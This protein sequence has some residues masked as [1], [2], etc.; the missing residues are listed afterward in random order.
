MRHGL[1]VLLT[2]NEE[3]RFSAA[4][5]PGPA[6]PTTG[7]S[8]RLV[9]ATRGRLSVRSPRNWK[10]VSTSRSSYVHLTLRNSHCDSAVVGPA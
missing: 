8:R 5:C 9:A 4:Q 10:V 6:P 1:T 3:S 7:D 2:P